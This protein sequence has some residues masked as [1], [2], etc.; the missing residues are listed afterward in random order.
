MRDWLLAA[1]SN[2]GSWEGDAVGK[3]YGTA[4]ALVI[5]QIPYGYLPILQR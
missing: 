4:I 5:L 2:D 3:V 1:Q